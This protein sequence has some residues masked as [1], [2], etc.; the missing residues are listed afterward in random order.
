MVC[1]ANR[2][3]LAPCGWR[4]ARYGQWCVVPTAASALRLEGFAFRLRNRP[5]FAEE[6]TNRSH[7]FILATE[8]PVMSRSNLYFPEFA[9]TSHGRRAFLAA[10]TAGLISLPTLGTAQEPSKPR[11]ANVLQTPRGIE[12]LATR[13][14]VVMQLSGTLKVA[15]PDPSSKK[16]PREAEVKAESTVEFEETD[17]H[18]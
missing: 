11:R 9:S 1:S 10:L 2:G 5:Y 8:P 12:Q 17:L 14:R 15:D 6:M 3:L 18:G 13:T 4:D 16:P 7:R